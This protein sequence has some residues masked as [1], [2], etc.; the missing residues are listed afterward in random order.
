MMRGWEYW[1][2]RA[3]CA[4]FLADNLAKSNARHRKAPS[5]RH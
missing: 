2:L 1:A 4:E 3:G 5:K